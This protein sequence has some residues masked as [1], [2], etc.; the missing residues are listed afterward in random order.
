[1]LACTSRGLLVGGKLLAAKPSLSGRALV[2]CWEVLKGFSSAGPILGGT[3]S[4]LS[5]GESTIP[6]Y[7]EA[8]DTKDSAG[9]ILVG[10][11]GVLGA[12]RLRRVLPSGLG[13]EFMVYR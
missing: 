10:A 6:L 7:E 9:N 4:L 12:R 11:S 5:V 1:M 3:F 2:M 13:L 8:L